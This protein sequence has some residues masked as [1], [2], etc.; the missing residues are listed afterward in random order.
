M[1]E[2]IFDFIG[3]NNGQWKIV[4]IDN[5][6]GETVEQVSHLKI[7]QSSLQKSNEGIWTLKGFRSN[8]RYTEKFE[9][10]SLTAIQAD[11]G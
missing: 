7:V 9:Q 6:I 3:G 8:L 1:I 11:L 4:R 10:E 5:V 2:N